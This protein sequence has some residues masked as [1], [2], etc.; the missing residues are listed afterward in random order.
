MSVTFVY[1]PIDHLAIVFAGKTPRAY[2][3]MHQSA[4]PLW[5]NN[6]VAVAIGILTTSA[7]HELLLF[8]VISVCIY[9][10]SER[11]CSINRACI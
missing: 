1:I 6:S 11:S 3:A 2:F 8:D 9:V 4:D 7:M 5:D 10:N